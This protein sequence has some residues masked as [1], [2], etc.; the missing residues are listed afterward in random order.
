MLN[1]RALDA[2]RQAAREV[3]MATDGPKLDR[4]IEAVARAA[5]SANAADLRTRFA[6]FD[7]RQNDPNS[8]A[9]GWMGAADYGDPEHWGI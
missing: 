5:L 8:F 3:G 7:V 4:L 1:E 9:A 2:A 6:N